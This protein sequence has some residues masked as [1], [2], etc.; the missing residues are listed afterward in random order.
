MSAVTYRDSC[1]TARGAA[2]HHTGG[3]PLCGWC[4]EAEAIARLRAES[5]PQRPPVPGADLL[6]PITKKQAA[7]N[8]EVLDMALDG[9]EWEPYPHRQLRVIK[10][11]K[12]SPAPETR[13]A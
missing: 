12:A 8:A 2:A 11:S 7:I 13:T 3:E 1:G 9:I 10:G 5:F 6:A 4:T